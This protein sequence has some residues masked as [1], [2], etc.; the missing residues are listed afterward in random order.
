MS[1]NW[2]STFSIWARKKWKKTDWKS[3]SKKCYMDN[4]WGKQK[5]TMKVKS[6]S[7]CGKEH[8]KGTLK[9]SFT[10]HKRKLLELIQWSIA[11]TRSLK[12]HAAG[13]ATKM[14]GVSHTP[15]ASAL[16]W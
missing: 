2:K 9:V 6:G 12:L 3:G 13:F 8:W 5:A 14:L 10:M 7:G 4:L 15:I 16:I 11:L 1:S